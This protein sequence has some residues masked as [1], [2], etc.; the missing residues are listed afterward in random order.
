MGFALTNMVAQ[1]IGIHTAAANQTQSAGIAYGRSQFPAAAPDHPALND[2]K[3][4][5]QK[6]GNT[7]FHINV[8]G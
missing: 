3:F 8:S 4:Y 7:V 2:G 6:P 1:D 5:A